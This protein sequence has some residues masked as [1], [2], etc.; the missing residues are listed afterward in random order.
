MW[1]QSLT[2]FSVITGPNGV[3]LSH[4][5][6]RAAAMPGGAEGGRCRD[7]QGVRFEGP[8]ERVSRRLQGSGGVRWRM[9]RKLAFI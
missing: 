4:G 8:G 2:P 1:C 6:G 7:R 3:T 5:A 9:A